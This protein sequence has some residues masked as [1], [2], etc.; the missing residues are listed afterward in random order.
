LARALLEI[1][2]RNK[3][4]IHKT[5]L[6]RSTTY[7]WTSNKLHRLAERDSR[8]AHYLALF[9]GL[10]LRLGYLATSGAK[11]DVIFLVGDPDFL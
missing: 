6:A 7:E 10:G 8:L 5:V 4:I 3:K 2:R 11:S 9:W 1:R